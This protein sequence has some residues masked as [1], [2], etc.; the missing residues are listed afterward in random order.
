MRGTTARFLLAAV[1]A[2][3]APAG[4]GAAGGDGRLT[5][6][7]TQYPGTLHPNIDSMAAKYYV[8]NMTNRPI[9]HFG[10]DWEPVC[11][12]CSKLPTLDNGL[13]ERE[14]LPDGG[15][16]L[17]IAIELHPEATWGD[18]TPVTTEDVVF[19]WEVGR[20]PQSGISNAEMY[21]RLLEVRVHD[22]KRFTFLTDRVTFRYNV[23]ADFRLL[24]AHIERPIFEADPAAYRNRTAF[25]SDPTNPGLAWGPYRIVR[26]TPGAEIALEPN[27]TWY[28]PPPA[29]DQIVVRAIE[30]TSALEANLLSGGIDMIAGESG[31]AVDQAIALEPRLGGRFEIDYVPGL[32]YEHID[33]LLDNPILG[34]RRV[35]QALLYGID[36]EAVTERLFGGR[37][38]VANSNV[39]PL[40]RVHSEEIPTYA[41]NPERAA[42]LLAEAGW[43]EL[44]DGVR[45]D[46]EGRALRLDFMTTAGNRTRELL[47][48]VLQS[49][50][51]EIGIDTRIRNETA[52]VFFGQTLDRRAYGGLALYAWFSSPEHVPRTTLHSEEIPREENGWVG[53]NFTGFADP[54]MDELIDTLEQELDFERRLELWHEIQRIYAE[55]LPVLPLF[56]RAEPHVIPTWLEGLRPTGHMVAAS[57]WVEDWRRAR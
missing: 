20:H 12:L 25:D 34:D 46:A 22:D 18:G 16:G 4:A 41:H 31:L 10:H 49:Q 48:Q 5:V 40:D 44:R 23:F 17:A 38:I 3:A 8:L 1:L 53:Q 43:E 57:M 51:R 52:R 14:A 28:G 37:N 50:W 56:W 24:P 39:S 7:I 19:T 55:E 54:R 36:R 21:R 32:F 11:F 29:F 15:E 45:H 6:G 35:R 30:N 2:V 9:S 47:Q 42:E 33:L 26:V 13:V 27:P